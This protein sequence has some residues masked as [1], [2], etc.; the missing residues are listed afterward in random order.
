LLNDCI[1][2]RKSLLIDFGSVGKGCKIKFHHC[3]YWLLFEPH[4][5]LYKVY[6]N[7]FF[8]FNVLEVASQW[9]LDNLS[10]F[11]FVSKVISL[12]WINLVIMCM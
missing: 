6:K 4:P 3:R 7:Y 11:F 1:K 5:A 2:I 12:I 8:A 9:T 10:K